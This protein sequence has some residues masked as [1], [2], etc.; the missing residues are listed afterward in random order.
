MK[1][2]HSNTGYRWLV[3]RGRYTIPLLFI[4]LTTPGGSRPDTDIA[5]TPLQNRSENQTY[6]LLN[7]SLYRI[8]QKIVYNI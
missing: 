4:S 2:N 8:M 6:E 7:N 3:S 5:Y 1:N